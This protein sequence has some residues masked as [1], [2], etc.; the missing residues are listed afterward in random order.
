MPPVGSIR[1][2]CTF[3]RLPIG[4]FC[5]TLDSR[6]CRRLCRRERA[7]SV[8]RSFCSDFRRYH[9]T[10]REFGRFGDDVNDAVD[11]IGAHNV[12]PG[13]SGRSIDENKW[14][15]G[16]RGSMDVRQQAAVLIDWAAVST[17]LFSGTVL[18]RAGVMLEDV[19]RIEVIRSAQALGRHCGAPMRSTASLTSSPKSAKLT[20]GGVVTTDSRNRRTNY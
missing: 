20:K 18:E 19:D 8:V 14:A 12:A 15:I 5:Y 11:R 17:P 10:F 16:S 9:S 6:H 2:R 1:T 3:R 4:I 13:H 7:L